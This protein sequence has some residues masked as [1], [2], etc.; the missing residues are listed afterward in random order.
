MKKTLKE[1]LDEFLNKENSL[2]KKKEGVFEYEF[3]T[4]YDE[5]LGKESLHEIM[6][7]D[8]PFETFQDKIFQ[9]YEEA[10]SDLYHDW[11]MRFLDV[12]G[13]MKEFES[14][15]MAMLYELV[16]VKIP[17]D[18]YKNQQFNVSLI[19]DSGSSDCRISENGTIS[20][21]HPLLWI[22][23]Q[24]GRTKSDLENTLMAE[25]IPENSFLASIRQENDELGWEHA[26]MH[27]FSI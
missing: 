27:F 6:E 12:C 24:Q 20:D 21:D 8:S 25:E 2:F 26:E 5:I 23:Q 15:I 19:V 7:S 3:Y 18:H 13:E 16:S 10:E 4:H 9:M 1:K 17:M 22:M 14:E 11:K